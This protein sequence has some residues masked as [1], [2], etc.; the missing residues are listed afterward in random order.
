MPRVCL[1]VL[2]ITVVSV[3]S[4][5]S[6]RQVSFILM[7]QQLQ[8]DHSL[9]DLQNKKLELGSLSLDEHYAT[10]V[11]ATDSSSLL[12]GSETEDKQH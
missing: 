9:S 3:W 10:S 6:A 5:Y 7:D 2:V 8:T 12:P 11:P 4:R 1:V